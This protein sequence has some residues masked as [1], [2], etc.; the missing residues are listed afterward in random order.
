ML[1]R[2]NTPPVRE[3]AS[4]LYATLL[5]VLR[6]VLLPLGAAA[7]LPAPAVEGLAA[8]AAA[9]GLAVAVEPPKTPL[10]R[11][12]LLPEKVRSARGAAAMDAASAPAP[13]LLV[14]PPPV[15]GL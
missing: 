8:M 14:R 13:A 10:V 6:A 5:A 11:A 15:L 4:P 9:T 7:P 2:A 3:V 1:V 12:V